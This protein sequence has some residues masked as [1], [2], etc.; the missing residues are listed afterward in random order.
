MSR[1]VV[2]FAT[3]ALAAA[4]STALST[5]GCGA[6][7]ATSAGPG[8]RSEQR[9]TSD[10][11]PT[12][13][14]SSA[15]RGVTGTP[16]LTVGSSA[17]VAVSVATV[18]RSPDSPR[19]VDDPALAQPARIEA[20]LGAMSLAE[21]RGLNGRA[22]T[23]ALLGDR[24]R[25]LALPADRPAWARVAVT[26]QPSPADSHGYPGWVPRRQLTS[27][28][29]TTS[30]Q[31]ATVVTRTAWLRTDQAQATRLFRISFA[32][33]LAVVGRAGGFVRVAG[34][35]GRVRRLAD[36][37]VVVHPSGQPARTPSR[38]SLVRTAKQF[39]GLP[40]LWAG[41]SG[42]GLDCSGLTWLD[43]RVHG[44]RIPRDALPQSQHGNPARPPRRGDLMFYATDGL[45][46]HVSMYVGDGF[47]V[48][49]PH[50]GARVEVIATR[51]P[52]YRSEYA[53]SRRYLP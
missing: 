23:Q 27:R 45:V 4:L 34:P 5:A 28:V 30:A 44:I 13:T 46:H 14:S 31:R 17:W 10:S 39:V 53:G 18:W 52:A 12:T 32:T 7:G 20:W 11:L 37:A 49:S 47:M 24:V 29:P 48:H 9:A 2:R 35:A 42:F 25:V 6:V 21:R 15:P 43:Y 16:G 22:D 51:T 3:F 1:S 41:V 36:S 40:Y 19:P 50:T 33:T 38:T 8:H 26:A